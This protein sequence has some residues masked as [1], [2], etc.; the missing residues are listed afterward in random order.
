MRILVTGAAGFIGSSVSERLLERGDEVVGLDNFDPFY[1]QKIKEH[2]LKELRTHS[3]FI[4]EEGD[5]LDS[6]RLQ[7]LFRR[8]IDRVVHLAALAGVRPS[9]VAPKRYMRVNVE[10]TVNLLEVCRAFDVRQVVVA[11]SSSVYGSRSVTPFSEEDSCD[12]PVSPYAASKKA[13]EVVCA[14]YHHLYQMGITCLRFFTVYGPRQRP[15]MAIHSFV[16]L[17]LQG[18]PL[19]MFGDGSSGRDYTYIDDIVEGTIAALDHVTQDFRIYN[20]G[21]SQPVL[22]RELIQAI[23]QATSCSIM[24]SPHPWQ[25]GDVPITSANI[26]RAQAELGYTPRV[27]LA[28]G[29]ARFVGWYQKQFA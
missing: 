29:L 3:G 22:L 14:T 20:L 17:A 10:G 13:T 19:P 11:S 16:R 26:Q 25:E 24:V 21:G 9:L 12:Y 7:E 15:E 23:G 28:E 18:K 27:P 5:I 6:E 4:F 2:N 1:D 8:K